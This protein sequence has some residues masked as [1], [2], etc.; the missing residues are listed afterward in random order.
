MK[1]LPEPLFFDW[2]GGNLSK[3]F[4]KHGVGNFEAEEAFMNAP[5]LILPDEEHSGVEKRKLLLGIANNNRRL[6]VVFTIRGNKIR[7]ISARDMS[8][9]ERRFCE[10]TTKKDSTIQNRG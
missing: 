6:S 4:I 3:N 1:E 10:E 5:I 9:K 8:K 2:S 7:I